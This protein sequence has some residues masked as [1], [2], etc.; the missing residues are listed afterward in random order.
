MNSKNHLSFS[1]SWL[2]FYLSMFYTNL[3]MHVNAIA[4]YRRGT[5]HEHNYMGMITPPYVQLN[6][7]P[8]ILC[9]RA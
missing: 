7:Y 4:I 9:Y 1:Q 6:N 5:V 8:I 2:G 3:K